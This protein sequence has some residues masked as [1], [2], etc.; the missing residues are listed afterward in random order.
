VLHHYLGWSVAEIAENL[1]VPAQT[2]KSRIRYATSTLRAALDADARTTS[3]TS[4]E[5]MA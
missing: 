1:G 5:R 2:I 4:R 3:L